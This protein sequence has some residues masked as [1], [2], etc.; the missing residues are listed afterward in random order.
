[1][2]D[3]AIVY[4]DGSYETFNIFINDFVDGTTDLNNGSGKFLVE[5]IGEL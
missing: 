5:F 2:D 3:I 1:M 4:P